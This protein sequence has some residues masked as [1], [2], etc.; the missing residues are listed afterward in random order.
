MYCVKTFIK[1]CAISYGIF[2]GYEEQLNI[3]KMTVK[4]IK[5]NVCYLMIPLSI[6]NW[7]YKIIVD[8]C[9]V[10]YCW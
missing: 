10:Y 3:F 7:C 9:K 8:Y 6:F 1:M 2:N 4:N 5:I